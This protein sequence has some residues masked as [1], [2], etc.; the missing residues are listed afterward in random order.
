LIR[1]NAIFRISA[2]EVYETAKP[3][4]ILQGLGDHFMWLNLSKVG[5]AW[6]VNE[7]L[8][9]YRIHGQSE[10]SK[11][12]LGRRD[13]IELTF[14]NDY[15]FRYEHDFGLVPRLLSKVNAMGRLATNFGVVR[16]ALEMMHS[17]KFHE[18]VAPVKA[19]F[20]SALR[21]VLEDFNYDVADNDP[22]RMRRLD[23]QAHINLLDRYLSGPD[24]ELLKHF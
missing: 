12:R 20:L 11:F 23:S 4:M 3:E 2:F 13:I 8:G 16:I 5:Q 21:Q 6:V 15:I 7:R 14:L 24:P 22:A 18:V 1:R 19:E 9:T 17:D 10:T